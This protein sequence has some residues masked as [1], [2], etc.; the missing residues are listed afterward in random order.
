MIT[1]GKSLSSDEA[2]D[3]AKKAI[4]IRESG[5]TAEETAKRIGRN[6]HTIRKYIRLYKS[7]G[8][9]AIIDYVKAVQI[10]QQ[11]P[12]RGIGNN[13][14]AKQVKLLVKKALEF[15][16]QRMTLKE[17]A[18]LVGCCVPSLSNYLQLYSE[19]G[20]EAIE[21]TYKSKK[22]SKS[23]NSNTR[24]RLWAPE[25]SNSSLWNIALFGREL[26]L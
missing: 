9:Q 19:G 22:K 12:K 24:D 2:I 1:G 20:Y 16:R 18:P 6:W 26:S 25:F 10:A 4:A 11:Q 3:V 5:I 21:K 15:K 17:I 23:S 14:T 7:G 8:E 13:P